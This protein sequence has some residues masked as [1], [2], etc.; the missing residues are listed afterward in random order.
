MRLWKGGTEKQQG[1]RKNI[2]NKN[3][4]TK[5]RIKAINKSGAYSRL[6]IDGRAQRIRYLRF[7][8]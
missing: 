2:K 3:P 6:Q 7:G 1:Y 4:N 5:W 8:F